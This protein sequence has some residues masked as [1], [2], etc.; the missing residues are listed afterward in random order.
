MESHFRL[1]KTAQNKKIFSHSTLLNIRHT[2][3]AFWLEYVKSTWE[4]LG[5]DAWHK[6][7][8]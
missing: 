1:K 3:T 8:S 7:R 6:Y 4:R 5:T 2:E